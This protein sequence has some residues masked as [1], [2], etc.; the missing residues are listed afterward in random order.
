MFTFRTQWY[1]NPHFRGT[2]SYQ[3]VASRQLNSNHVLGQPL[4]NRN[5]NV[6]LMF[7]GE[8]THTSYYAT[9]HGAIQTGYREAERLL[10][11]IGPRN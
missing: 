6:T 10:K 5:G 1:T 11:I 7:A 8:A 2:Y 4:H 3:T 9:V